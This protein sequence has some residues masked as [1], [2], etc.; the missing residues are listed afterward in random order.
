MTLFFP[1]SRSSAAVVRLCSAEG[2]THA[3]LVTDIISR[4]GDR[5]RRAE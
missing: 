1:G 2:Q 3:A 4:F 5:R